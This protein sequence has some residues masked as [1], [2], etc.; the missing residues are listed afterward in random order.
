M[1]TFSKVQKFERDDL[2][3]HID[4]I[5]DLKA[6]KLEAEGDNIEDQLDRPDIVQDIIASRISYLK[7]SFFE[8]E[9][10]LS[11]KKSGF[12]FKFDDLV[13]AVFR[14]ATVLTFESLRG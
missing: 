13:E 1:K 5:T 8:K 11:L 9:T 6:L 4:L 14:R 2:E 12:K 10:K 7:D 3:A